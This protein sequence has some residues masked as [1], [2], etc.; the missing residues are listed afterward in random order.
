M[1]GFLIALAQLPAA[2]PARPTRCATSC[3]Y[4]HS[5]LNTIILF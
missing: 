4:D 3:F 2:R 1:N 5:T